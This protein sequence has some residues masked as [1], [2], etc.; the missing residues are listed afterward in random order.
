MSEKPLVSI[1]TP[2]YAREAFL[3]LCHAC[4][5]SQTGPAAEW[6]VFDDSPAPSERLSGL[7]D[8][9]VTYFHTSQR[10]T[11]GEKRNY[12]AARAKGDIIVH[13]DD[14]D[15]YAPRYVETMVAALESGADM[16]KLSGWFL[17]SVGLKAFGYWDCARADLP[18]HVWSRVGRRWADPPDAAVANP[19]AAD[20]NLLG[21]GF[22]YAYRRAVW[23]ATGFPPV[24]AVE[25]APFARAARSGFRFS[26]IPDAQG[27]CLHVLHAR[28]TSM[29]MPQYEL[30]P[31]L[32]E[33]LFGPAA[34]AH[35]G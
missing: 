1:I 28:S 32:V 4:V 21:Y 7:N 20:D 34:L 10:V 30:P 26:A 12:L 25:D 35:L 6:L 2:S 15:Y 31:T 5:K 8:P 23:E 24:N 11:I 9:Q 17:Y 33:R 29:C 18:H 13:F 14:D 22:S 27:L 19:A 16:V 3:S